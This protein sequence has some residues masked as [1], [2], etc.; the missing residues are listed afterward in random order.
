MEKK[1]LTITPPEG[2]EI[3]RENSTFEHIVFKEIKN[4][5]TYV[6]VAKKLFKGK[7]TY[8]ISDSGIGTF[9]CGE[10]FANYGNCVTINQAKWIIALNKLQNVAIYLNNGWKPNLNDSNELKCFL[11]YSHSSKSLNI[12]FYYVSN[13][14]TVY[15]KS[16]ELAKQAIEI[17]GEE[18]VKTALG[19]YKDC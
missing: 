7:T 6:D 13:N 1:E 19:V 18:T 8:F 10:G 9:Q 4:Q 12:G 16:E 15:F 3:D 11:K 17:L 14:G 5:M 2:Y